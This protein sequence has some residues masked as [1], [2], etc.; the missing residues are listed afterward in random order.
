MLN[1]ARRD[2]DALD[3]ET[4]GGVRLV[5]DFESIRGS[6]AGEGGAAKR[7]PLGQRAA[8]GVRPDSARPGVPVAPLLD[9]TQL[10]RLETLKGPRRTASRRHCGLVRGSLIGTSS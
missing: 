9:A 2:F 1:E 3:E 6:T 5:V 10:E 7:E 8:S 4:V